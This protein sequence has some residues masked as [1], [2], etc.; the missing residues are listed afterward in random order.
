MGTNLLTGSHSPFQSLWSLY[1]RIRTEG[2]MRKNTVIQV[3]PAS[4]LRVAMNVAAEM[5]YPLTHY[6][7]INFGL[8]TCTL[9]G[10]II[11]FARLREMFSKWVKRGSLAALR[12]AHTW[13]FENPNG[14]MHVNWAVHVPKGRE[15]A[16]E[17]CLSRWLI[18][19]TGGS[20]PSNAVCIRTIYDA[21]RLSL[22]F[23][24]G[25][26]EAYTTYS[27]IRHEP[28]GEISG[29]RSGVARSLNRNARKSAG[30]S[31][32]RPRRS[33]AASSIA[34]AIIT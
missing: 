34:P 10:E 31:G 16:F 23:L 14:I 2:R 18:R 7:V 26:H 12:P 30:I 20:Y 15:A 4:N 1:G 9:G 25:A 22:Y 28:Q 29:R 32:K 21:G 5:G 3:K 8:T 11:A 13:A 17:A 33:F 27:N 19:T 24:K 6:V